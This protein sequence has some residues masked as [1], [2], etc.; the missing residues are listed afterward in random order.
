MAD[1]IVV[2]AA[3]M[4]DIIMTMA[5]LMTDIIVDAS[6]MTNIIV[7]ASHMT[8]IIMAIPMN[9]RVGIHEFIVIFIATS[10]AESTWTELPCIPK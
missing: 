5:A 8:N 1:I 10:M 9:S 3:T 7:D 4:T 2:M 6:H